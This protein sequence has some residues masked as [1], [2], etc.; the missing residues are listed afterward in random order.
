M[1]IW[2]KLFGGPT[3][4][5]MTDEAPACEV[6]AAD[7]PLSA[8][9]HASLADFGISFYCPA[10]WVKVPTNGALI[11]RAP[12][13]SSFAYGPELIFSPTVSLIAADKGQMANA[14]PERTFSEFRRHLPSG[15]ADAKITDEPPFVIM[16]K[17]RANVIRLEF[18]KGD[19]RM[20]SLMAHVVTRSRQYIFDG[21]ALDPDFAGYAATFR[22]I[23]Q[24]LSV[25]NQ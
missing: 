2:K 22:K 8:W 10:G 13:A 20:T 17:H 9:N 18:R 4:S 6:G 23:L 25:P 19:R 16:S 11:M 15:F 14:S 3:Q 7:Y 12:D 1:S 21:C 24:S 5:L